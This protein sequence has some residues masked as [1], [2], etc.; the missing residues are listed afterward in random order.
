MDEVFKLS[1]YHAAKRQYARRTAVEEGLKGEALEMRIRQLVNEP[2]DAVKA[3]AEDFA[4][5]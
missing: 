1:A 3:K 4:R 2:S 5:L